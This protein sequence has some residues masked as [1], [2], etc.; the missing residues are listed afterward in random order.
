MIFKRHQS[1]TQDNVVKDNQYSVG[2][3]RVGNPKHVMPIFWLSIIAAS[4]LHFVV[5]R[6]L[7]NG[8]FVQRIDDVPSMEQVEFYAVSKKLVG[9]TMFAGSAAILFV[10]FKSVY[11]GL[12]ILTV[13]KS[14]DTHSPDIIQDADSPSVDG[15][16]QA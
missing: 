16:K 5:F 3:L 4:I 8:L 12:Y 2:F 15:D 7:V 6:K 14:P 13:K 1:H 11:N 10:I 9:F